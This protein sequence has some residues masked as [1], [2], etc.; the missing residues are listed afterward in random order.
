MN[1]AIDDYIVAHSSN[2]P[3]LLQELARKTHIEMLKANMLSGKVQGWLLNF[4]VSMLKP[5]Q[6]LEIG[7]YTGY[8]ALAMAMNQKHDFILHTIEVNPENAAFA[9]AFFEQYKIQN[10]IKLHIGSALNIIPEINSTFDLVFIDADKK[11]YS[12]YYDL[13]FD[14]VNLGGII[15][16]DNVLWYGKVTNPDAQDADTVALRAFNDKVTKDHRVS[17]FIL[18]LRDGLMMV[19][20]DKL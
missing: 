8:S 12:K 16:A 5:K 18:P 17:N 10:Q 14:K 2:E 3:Q 11:N 9:S 4:V 20:K 19:K 1:Q 6:I 7:T 13:V 15:I